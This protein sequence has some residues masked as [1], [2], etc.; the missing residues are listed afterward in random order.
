[1]LLRIRGM[2]SGAK[3]VR[4]WQSRSYWQPLLLCR[5]LARVLHRGRGLADAIY[6]A[7]SIRESACA[8]R[9]SWLRAGIRIARCLT[10]SRLHGLLSEVCL[11]LSESLIVRHG[12]LICTSSFLWLRKESTERSLVARVRWRRGMI[13]QRCGT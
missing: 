2:C 12:V 10:G 1:M 13:D 3:G 6:S 4:R 11:M 8:R 9:S 5:L 7:L